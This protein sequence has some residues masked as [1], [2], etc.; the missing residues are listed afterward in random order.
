MASTE[1]WA[2]VMRIGMDAVDIDMQPIREAGLYW[3][4]FFILFVLFGDFFI[5]NLFAGAVVM[6]FNKEKERLGKTYLLTD[7]QKRW[8]E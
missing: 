5:M 4:L 8:L 6:T 1:G 3:S 7:K 2:D